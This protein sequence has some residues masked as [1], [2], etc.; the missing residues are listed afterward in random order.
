MRMKH[1]L[2]L[3]GVL[4]AATKLSISADQTKIPV[5]VMARVVSSCKISSPDSVQE[6]SVTAAT[7]AVRVR[8]RQ[9]DVWNVD[10]DSGKA[11]ANAHAT[12]DVIRI[13]ISF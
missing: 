10:I 6:N 11:T 3:L 5:A 1:A 8:C 7:K 2:L 13:T 9:P 12:S 4:A